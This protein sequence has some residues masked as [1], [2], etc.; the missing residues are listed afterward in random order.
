M[1]ISVGN[2]DVMMMKKMKGGQQLLVGYWIVLYSID[3]RIMDN[4][5]FNN[6]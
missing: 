6:N 3:D 5:Q 2:E 1:V 4:V